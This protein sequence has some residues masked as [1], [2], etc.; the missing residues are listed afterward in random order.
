MLMCAKI[1]NTHGI[2][3]EVKALLYADSPS[4][5]DKIKKLYTKT[6]SVLQ[7]R[8]TRT[9]RGMLIFK[10]DGI[11]SV[12]EAEKL[13]DT[14]LYVKREDAGELPE[15]RYYIADLLG[16]SV[17]TDEGRD[18]GKVA[19]VFSTGANDVYTVKG[20]DKEFLIPV[21]DDVILST[22][23]EGGKIIIKP[24]KGLLDDED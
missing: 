18:L 19:D 9:Q 22:D 6:G 24:L 11:D 3:G 7:I 4:F 15:G 21:I 14:E 17:F 13:R 12:D 5:F 8:S 1:V 16:L 2:N 20:R 23:I 10:F